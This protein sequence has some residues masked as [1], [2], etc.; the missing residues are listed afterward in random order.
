ME[1]NYWEEKGLLFT[2]GELSE[3]EVNAFNDHLKTCELCQKELQLYQQER[4]T[5]FRPEMFEDAPPALVDSEILRV[6]SQP[7]KP[8]ITSPI[9]TTFVKN[10]IY[11]VL[12]FAVGFGGGAYF[13]ANKT[14]SD[15]RRDSLTQ[16]QK[17]A[18]SEQIVS[19]QQRSTDPIKDTK[20]TAESD[21]TPQD[22]KRASDV[23]DIVPVGVQDK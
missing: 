20:D 10:V 1:C 3:E 21:S 12:I 16:Q 6:C 15:A 5:L 2:S 18:P 7:I 8:T 11:A 23:K 13:V 14:A 9:F 19:D 4:E 22:F 17:I